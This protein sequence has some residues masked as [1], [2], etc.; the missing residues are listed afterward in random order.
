MNLFV[1][2]C[3]LIALN[4]LD[5]GPIYRLPWFCH[6]HGLSVSR[7][8]PKLGMIMFSL[9][10]DDMKVIQLWLQVGPLMVLEFG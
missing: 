4:I 8:P 5:F 1:H 2:V 9:K 6:V 10:S 7:V 3:A